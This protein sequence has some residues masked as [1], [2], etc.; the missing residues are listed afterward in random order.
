VKHERKRL[1]PDNVPGDNFFHDFAGAAVDT[2]DA[3]V[4]V[5]AGDGVFLHV[6]VA[7]EQ[8]QTFV[9]NH[10]LQL[11]GGE[12]GDGGV[13]SGEFVAIVL[14]NTLLT[15]GAID[16]DLGVQVRQNEAG[17]LQAGDRLAKR[18]ALLG[19]F[20]GALD[21]AFASSDGAQ[22]QDQAFAGQFV[23]QVGEAFAFT[24]ENL[25]GADFHVFEEQLGGVRRVVAHFFQVAATG[26]AVQCTIHGE[27]G[28]AFGTGVRV[29]LG[30]EHDHVAVLAVGDEGFLAADAVAIAVLVGT[31]FHALQVRTGTGFGHADGAYGFTG[32]HFRQPGLFLLFVA[33]VQ[34]VR[35][36]D[37]GV[38]G[39]VGRQCT[40]TG[41]G[42][43]FHN[44]RR[45]AEVGAEAAVFF[46]DVHTQQAI[47]AHLI[48]QLAGEHFGFFP[49]VVVRSD[50]VFE[51]FFDV[52]AKQFD[53]VLIKHV[54]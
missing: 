11:G 35:S 36:D 29:G 41:A 31:G 9:G 16:D 10:A 27:Q 40:K 47:F 24:T 52:I 14:V 12:L 21:H 48:P 26:K 49:L 17:V 28:H 44:H 53:F 5:V 39:N 1:T 43:F 54:G 4:H 37:V 45:Q 7:T 33:Q 34:D 30:G 13:G 8:L 22:G 25:V 32:D 50:F 38:H 42:G 15:V 3:G 46:R 2:L 23:H 18:H 20:D 19:V 51:E 6:A